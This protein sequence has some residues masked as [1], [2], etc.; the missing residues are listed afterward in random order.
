MTHYFTLAVARRGNVTAAA[1]MEGNRIFDLV[2]IREQ[3]PLRIGLRLRD[4][5]L[6]YDV[7]E[8]V[9]ET[10]AAK[11]LGVPPSDR[12]TTCYDATVVNRV[13]VP[14]FGWGDAG[15]VH[16]LL[17]EQYPELDRFLPKG[18][19]RRPEHTSLL[20]AVALGVTHH[21]YEATKPAK[22]R[23]PDAP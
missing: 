14:D 16:A 17:R 15:R 2:R 19:I 1:V 8:L 22:P 7:V 23:A 11:H 21:T 6:R 4:A 20:A 12:P 9:F 10:G 18:R 13:I 3:S 5:V